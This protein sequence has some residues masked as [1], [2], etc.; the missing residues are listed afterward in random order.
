[1]RLSGL[2]SVATLLL[3]GNAA[4]QYIFDVDTTVRR[5]RTYDVVHYKI[6]VDLNDARKRVS[7]TTSVTLT[8]LVDRLDSVVL[9]AVDMEVRRV[10]QEPQLTRQ[11]ANRSPKLVVY[12]DP[13]ATPA[14]TLTLAIT[15]SCTPKKGL[16]FIQPDSTDPTRRRQIWTQG[17]DVDNSSWFPC[18]DFPNDMATSEV[19][20]TVP[21]FYTLLSNGALVSET[22]DTSR[23]TRTF[24]WRQAKPHASYLIMIAASDFA[25]V[26]DTAG[27]VPLEY[28]LYK[29]RVEDGLRSFARTP[30][31]MAYFQAIIGVPYPWEKFAQVLAADFVTGAMENT[32]AVTY[33]DLYLLDQR[34]MIDFT[35]DDV[36]AHELSHQWWG[37][38]VTCRD[39]THL[40]LNEGFAMY[41]EALFKRHDRGV[42]VFQHEKF[43]ETQTI[44]NT[45][46]SLGRRP[47]VSKE[48]YTSNVYA[49]GGWVLYMLH[50]ILGEEAFWKG[51]RLYLDRYTHRNAETNDLALED[52]TGRNMDWF[53]RQW[54]YR[55]GQ[56]HLA[57]T[58]TWDSTSSTHRLVLDQ[59]QPLDSL[60]GIFRFPLNIEYTTSIGAIDTML[61]VTR[62]HTEITMHLPTRPEMVIVDRGYTLLK[63]L[64]FE[65]SIEEN[66]YQLTHAKDVADR[67][68]AA[69]DLRSAKNNP[70]VFEGLRYSA[71]QDPFW[72]VRQE[73]AISLGVM[74]GENVRSAL[75]DLVRDVNSRVRQAA[76]VA[77]ERF[78]SPEVKVLLDSVAS[79]DSSYLVVGSCI[80]AMKEVDS[81]YAF[82]MAARYVAMESYRNIVRRAALGVLR[83][84]DDP[85][86]LPIALKYAR[87]GQ[88]SDIRRL[89]VAIVGNLGR[90]DQEAKSL[91][92][93]LVDDW[94]PSVR[95]AA[96]AKLSEWGGDEAREIIQKRKGVEE[97]TSVV[98]AINEAL[99]HLSD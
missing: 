23:Q 94:D 13:P 46:R 20:A 55:A 37:D 86:A 61:W 45:E 38:V 15:Y 41:F 84:L 88:S 91:M 74:T 54:V 70:E 85:R 49:K 31:I 7:G 34:A 2:L 4:G 6:A 67:I 26:R 48:S 19:V 58:Q 75:L 1:M 12:L 93:A 21:T 59:V 16:Y 11:F 9:D 35:T 51:V 87:P 39:W 36:V 53:F 95:R 80:T 77:L 10:V 83:E 8:P 32:S 71:Q 98:G 30:D 44:R 82:D 62:Q 42:D 89:A 40:W 50:H 22:V 65:K 68:N 56:P 78:P 66:L 5:S 43:Q 3:T 29:D 76:V 64:T 60:T 73:A 99:E 92:A 90:Q 24:H 17:E 33:N 97:E 25:I 18:Y 81:T 47:I 57:V 52:A 72:A 96:V 14:D 28:Y 63:T 69:R 27:N 79:C